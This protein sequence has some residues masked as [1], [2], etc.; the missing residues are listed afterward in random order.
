MTT[1]ATIDRGEEDRLL[2]AAKAGGAAG[3]AAAQALVLMHRGLIAKIA[4]SYSRRIGFDDAYQ[5][6]L[7]GFIKGIDTY[8][9]GHGT[10]FTSWAVW[11]MRA[12]CQAEIAR[13]ALPVCVATRAYWKMVQARRTG[14][15]LPDW[16]SGVVRLDDGAQDR[17][18]LQSAEAEDATF[19]LLDVEELF[20]RA[21]LSESVRDIIRRRLLNE[22]VETLQAI[23]TS[24]GLTRERVRQIEARALADL[25]AVVLADE[26]FGMGTAQDPAHGK[27][28]G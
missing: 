13:M 23:G 22:E 26:R 7:L 21:G 14:A 16:A 18:Q 10:Q 25:R 2:T 11:P 15:P 20:E 3:R 9:R 6:A 8:Q 4:Q 27:S 12:A 28:A 19:G 5:A 24:R 17:V 1:G